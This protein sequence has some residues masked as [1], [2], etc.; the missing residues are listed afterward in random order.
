MKLSGNTAGGDFAENRVPGG[1]NGFGAETMGS[2]EPGQR[3]GIRRPPSTR[4]QRKANHS[5][6]PNIYWQYSFQHNISVVSLIET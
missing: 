1:N 2:D 6:S 3:T 4:H 5:T